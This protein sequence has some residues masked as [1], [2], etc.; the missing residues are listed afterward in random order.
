IDVERPAK[1]EKDTP[2]A[3]PRIEEEALPR[4]I[5]AL[6]PTS[7]AKG[8][9]PAAV[10]IGA[11]R[12]DRELRLARSIA[13]RRRSENAKLEARSRATL[14]V[15]FERHVH[16]RVK[17]RRE[18][19]HHRDKERSSCCVPHAN[20][21]SFISRERDRVSCPTLL[22]AS[23]FESFTR[24][25]RR[26]GHDRA[27]EARESRRAIVAHL[28]DDVER[29]WLVHARGEKARLDPLSTHELDVPTIRA[30]LAV[31]PP[32]IGERVAIRIAAPRG[33]ERHALAAR[34]R[35]RTNP[36][37]PVIIEDGDGGMV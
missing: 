5:G 20:P 25:S 19:E 16:A 6:G 21:W 28:E 12:D 22:A 29:H 3:R 34:L 7:V 26:H 24:S 8:L 18:R 17:R 30:R 14:A 11:T 9:E 32:R 2:A 27:P 33:A 4:A 10:R 31:D 1:V 35:H 13:R 37:R 36:A 15:P 23:S